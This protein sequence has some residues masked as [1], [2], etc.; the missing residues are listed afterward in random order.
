MP[1]LRK[2]PPG[3]TA[4]VW[5]SELG[6]IGLDT[7]DVLTQHVVSSGKFVVLVGDRLFELADLRAQT[8]FCVGDG[9]SLP[10]V[11]RRTRCAARCGAE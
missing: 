10:D 11:G 7:Y 5:G 2:L 8:C 1:E 9:A 4:V 6:Y 3:Q